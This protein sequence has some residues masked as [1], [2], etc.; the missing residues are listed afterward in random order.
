M[1]QLAKMILER[2]LKENRRKIYFDIIPPSALEIYELCLCFDGQCIIQTTTRNKFCF[3]F[4]T[5]NNKIA[6]I[7]RYVKVLVNM[8]W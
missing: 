6:S 5:H 8:N 2:T 1:Q 7:F 4:N 3:V